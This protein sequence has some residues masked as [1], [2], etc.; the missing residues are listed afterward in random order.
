MRSVG[1][2]KLVCK[3]DKENEKQAKDVGLQAAVTQRLRRGAGLRGSTGV[4]RSGARGRRAL[5]GDGRRRERYVGCSRLRLDLARA[6]HDLNPDGRDTVDDDEEHCDTREQINHSMLVAIMFWYVRAG[7]GARTAGLGG[8]WLTCRVAEPS[9]LPVY[10]ESSWTKRWPMFY[11]DLS[12][13][14]LHRSRE[15]VEYIPWCA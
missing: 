2:H 5:P 9:G 14:L 6:D 1:I 10:V 4:L 3:S 12:I 11:N 15:F 8:S 13:P 7:P